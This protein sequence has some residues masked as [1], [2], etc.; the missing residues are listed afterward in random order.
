MSKGRQSWN[1][2]DE[3]REA[4]NQGDPQAQCYLGVC[5]QTGSL[6]VASDAVEA[7]RW[8]RKAGFKLSE[9]AGDIVEHQVHLATN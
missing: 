1:S 5:F 3:V 6:G 9:R 2:L 4:A 7:V 8:F